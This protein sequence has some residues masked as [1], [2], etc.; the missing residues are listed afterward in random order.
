[1]LDLSLLAEAPRAGEVLFSLVPISRTQG[2]NQI[3]HIVSRF[4]VQQFQVGGQ[5]KKAGTNQKATLG[6]LQGEN[7][8]IPRRVQRPTSTR[9]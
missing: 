7:N 6:N 2:N 4:V 3:F 9:A 5:L 8:D 1:M